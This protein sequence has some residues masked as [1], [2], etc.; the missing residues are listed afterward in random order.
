MSKFMLKNE[1]YL[2]CFLYFFFVLVL[3][4]K[5]LL[6]HWDAFHSILISSL[7]K[8]PLSFY[9]FYMAKLLMPLFIANF[10]FITKRKWW[11]IIISLLVDIWCV[12]NLIYYKTYD[13]FLS[14]YDMLLVNNMEGAWSSLFA[15]FD[16]YMLFMFLT[17]IILGI[18]CFIFRDIIFTKRYRVFLISILFVMI[19][20]YLNNNFI[21]NPKF[22]QEK[23]NEEIALSLDQQ[24]E[25]IHFVNNHGGSEKLYES[26]FSYIPYFRVFLNATDITNDNNNFMDKYIRQQSII[27]D[28]IAINIFYIFHKNSPGDIIQLDDSDI[29]LIKPFFNNKDTTNSLPRHSLIVILVESLECWPLLDSI[30]G[31]DITPNLRKL[32]QQENVLFCS[33]LKSQTLGGNSGDGQ[34]IVNTGLLPI[35]NGVACM[36]YRDNK[37][38]DFAHFYSHS[39]LI[40]PWPKIWNQDTMSIRYS[41]INKIEPSDQSWQDADVMKILLEEVEKSI[42]PSCFFAIT[43]STHSPFNRVINDKINTSAPSILNR[44]I[45]CLNY[46]DS[47]IGSFMDNFLSSPMSMHST[48]VITSDHTIFKPKML[49]DFK[50][51]MTIH[52]LS[53]ASGENYCPL[54]VYSPQINGNVCIDDI[55]YQ[56][57]VYPTILHLIG[58]EDYY[59]KGFGVNLMDSIARNNRPISEEDAYILSDKII[60]SDYFRQYANE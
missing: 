47:C 30:E 11:T 36:N 4:V 53:L 44:Y 1:K 9:K 7:W 39:V 21:Y 59:W 12:S 22:W 52:N 17:T 15:Y 46:A 23:S 49:S 58:C 54:L 16:W 5:C 25:W 37:Y 18:L 28:F 38:P 35:Q 26:P 34:M 19:L 41:Y 57:D 50:D 10:C 6:F 29:K 45:K 42:V 51:Y 3:F 55:C 13:E 31:N 48:V 32:K 33:K 2:Q 24:S 43:V 56:M 20:S 60:R 8:N 27:S 14:V 40:N